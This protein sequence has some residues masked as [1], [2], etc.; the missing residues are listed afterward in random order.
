MLPHGHVAIDQRRDLVLLCVFG[1]YR[2]STGIK[3]SQARTY[4][5]SFSNIHR[6]TNFDEREAESEIGTRLRGSWTPFI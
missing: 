2:A 4:A 3:R 5:V 6:T 1:F